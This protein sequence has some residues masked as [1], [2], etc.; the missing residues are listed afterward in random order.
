MAGNRR[1]S[2]H[3]AVALACTRLRP[4]STGPGLVE[5]CG[6]VVTEVGFVGLG[7]M[8]QP[9]AVNLARTGTPLVVWNRTAARTEAVVNAGAKAVDD[10]DD[11]LSRTTTV[12]FMMAN[13]AALDD[14]LGRGSDLF[15][16]R[17]DGHLIVSLGTTSPEFSQQLGEDIVAAGG[18]YVEAPVSGSREPAERAELVGMLAG[19]PEDVATVRPLVSAMCRVTFECGAVP[20]ALLMKLSVNLFLITMVAG[21]AEATHFAERHGLDLETFR[22]VLD[23]GPMSSSVSRAKLAMLVSREFPVAAALGDVLMNSQLV[24][25]AARKRGVAAP[26]IDASEALFAEA[27]AMGFGGD[28]MAAVIRAFERRTDA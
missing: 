24:V 9:M 25:Q 5:S 28:D 22:S 11:V 19:T 2:T 17:V 15:R 26:L 27:V 7:V 12:F 16:R 10:L 1:G 21:L 20:T 4:F 13:G 14:V 6:G 23:A 3:G 18:R 8:G